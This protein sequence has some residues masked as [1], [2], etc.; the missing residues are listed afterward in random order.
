MSQP[1]RKRPPEVEDR[2]RRLFVDE[3]KSAAEVAAILGGTET[4]N[5]IVALAHHRGWELQAGR[6]GSTGQRKS[7]KYATAPRGKVWPAPETAVPY[8]HQAPRS[9][10][11]PVGADHPSDMSMHLACGR[12]TEE[13][14]CAEH[15]AASKG[16]GNV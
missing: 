10:R 4:R 16:K 2:I 12:A 6:K 3:G 15:K 11:W 7:T 13:R 5:T 8:V 1:Q 14:Y 9:C